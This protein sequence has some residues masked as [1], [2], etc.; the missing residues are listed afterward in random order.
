MSASEFQQPNVHD[1]FYP[2]GLPWDQKYQDLDAFQNIA[3]HDTYKKKNVMRGLF[4]KM[5]KDIY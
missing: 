2:K 3:K 1:N 5:H 4:S